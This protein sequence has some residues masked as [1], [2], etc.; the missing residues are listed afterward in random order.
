MQTVLLAIITRTAKTLIG[1][2]VFAVVISPSCPLMLV[3]IASRGFVQIAANLYR[4]KEDK[5][6]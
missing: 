6:S 5:N 3:V 4:L 1:I 2:T